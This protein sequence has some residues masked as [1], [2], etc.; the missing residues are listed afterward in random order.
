[1]QIKGLASKKYF[2]RKKK[3]NYDVS[4]IKTSPSQRQIEINRSEE[5]K[6]EKEKQSKSIG[7]SRKNK[8]TQNRWC[9]LIILD[10]FARLL[11]VL[12]NE[13]LI[14]SIW[15]PPS[16]VRMLLAYPS[17]VSEYASEHLVEIKRTKSCYTSKTRNCYQLHVWHQLT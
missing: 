12:V 8:V 10:F 4:R 2:R 14:P 6:K 16:T 9:T 15:V 3:L 5:E 11:R 7:I 17:I 1:M 13:A